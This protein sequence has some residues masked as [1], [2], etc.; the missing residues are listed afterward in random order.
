MTSS[1]P[2]HSKALIEVTWPV[3]VWTLPCVTWVSVAVSWA[4]VVSSEQVTL[5]PTHAIL[6]LAESSPYFLILTMELSA[7]ADVAVRAIVASVAT[8]APTVLV[9]LFMCLGPL[10]LE[11]GKACSSHV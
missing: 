6:W 2:V 5:T 7:L 9:V 10:G 11:I 1:S 4:L 3:L 8:P